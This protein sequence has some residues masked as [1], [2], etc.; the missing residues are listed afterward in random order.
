L[1][2]WTKL[3]ATNLT[4]KMLQRFQICRGTCYSCLSSLGNTWHSYNS[5]NFHHRISKIYISFTS[6]TSTSWLAVHRM[7]IQCRAKLDWQKLAICHCPCGG[8]VL[9]TLGN[10]SLLLAHIEQPAQT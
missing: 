8:T 3:C 2:W 5:Y 7:V 6:F 9:H 10:W 4:N 1:Q